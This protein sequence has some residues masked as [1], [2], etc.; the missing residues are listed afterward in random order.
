MNAPFKGRP[1]RL[2]RTSARRAG[3]A[4]QLRSVR[5][6]FVKPVLSSEQRKQASRAAVPSRKRTVTKNSKPR[7]TLRASRPKETK[8]GT[9]RPGR[10]SLPPQKKVIKNHAAK[11]V[12]LVKKSTMRGSTENIYQS[13]PIRAQAEDPVVSVIIPVMNERRTLSRVL[14]EAAAVHPLT[15][16][17][18]VANGS[19]DG[20]IQIAERAG[21]RLLVYDKPLGHDVGR[22]V[23]AQAARG[24]VLLFIDGD[25]VIPAAKL[26]PFVHA[27]LQGVDVALNDYSGPVAKKNVHSVVLAKHA[28]NTMLER[29]ELRGTSM[30]A[31]PH[32]ISRNA[33]QHIGAEA[34]SVPPL[35]HAMA[36]RLGL[37]VEPVHYVN[38][39]KLN[40]PRL[41]RERVSPLEI[42]IL[43]DHLEA[44]AWMT[45]QAGERGGFM[46]QHRSREMV[47]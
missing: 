18:V 40:P 9:K 24:S 20:S 31:I 47:R 34:L 19:T 15:E 12:A 8:R 42:V 14:R 11:P 39:G 29:P 37:R 32:A 6:L 17:I 16:V 7:K 44:I 5:K 43:G 23:G 41:E 1:M 45:S 21:A 13:V 36:V 2:S 25:M 26:R 10:H 33:L 22:S 28:L 30:T 46:D 4:A 3:R 27:V 35:A 38:V